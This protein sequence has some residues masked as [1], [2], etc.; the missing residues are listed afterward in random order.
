MHI[1]LP[2]PLHGWREF[3]G[4]VGIIVMGVLIALG[5]E[6]VIE[7]VHHRSQVHDAVAKLRAESLGNQD[8]LAFSQAGLQQSMAGIDRG[9]SSTGKL[10]APT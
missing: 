10:R 7:A 6:Q 4:E 9:P 3:V 5:A 2:K 1:H 8:G